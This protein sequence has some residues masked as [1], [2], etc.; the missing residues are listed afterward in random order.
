MHKHSELYTLLSIA[1]C[2]LC[3]P[4]MVSAQ[5]S[6]AS[7]LNKPILENPSLQQLMD[8]AIARLPPLALP[9][10]R[11]SSLQTQGSANDDAKVP[12]CH[13]G[14]PAAALQAAKRGQQLY[15]SALRVTPV[16]NAQ[17]QDAL[18]AFDAQCAAGDDWALEFRAYAQVL[19][20]RDLAAAMSLD[21]FLAAHTEQSLP[22]EARM[23][24][25]AYRT[26]IYGRV[27]S[28]DV[29]TNLLRVNYQLDGSLT[30]PLR[31]RVLRLPP[32]AHVLQLN[33]P[34]FS[35]Y[36]TTLLLSAGQ[37]IGLDAQLLP[38]LTRLPATTKADAR[39][40]KPLESGVSAWPIVLSIAAGAAL[41]TG[42]VGTV[43]A[44]GA[45]DDYAALGCNVNATPEGCGKLESR[46]TQAKT[47]QLAGFIA[48]GVLGAA[49]ITW[50]TVD[51]STSRER[52]EARATLRGCQLNVAGVVCGGQL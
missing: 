38:E 35:A 48:G 13:G 11:P 34:G 19:L 4:F 37:Y 8:G 50:F 32:G 6:S 42:V 12:E 7:P 30:Q 31:A 24:V 22:A 52:R 15:E 9:S 26:I 18:E 45:A 2:A 14:Q 43:R 25:R 21:A 1:A 46:F 47:M 41:A 5:A 49:A 44:F 10:E 16:D 28:V 29:S 51:A 36:R 17:L 20:G 27:A 39:V 23:R 40:A 3:M 33:A